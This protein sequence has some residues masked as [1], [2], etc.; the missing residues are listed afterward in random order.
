VSSTWEE[1]D[2]QLKGQQAGFSDERGCLSWSYSLMNDPAWGSDCPTRSL[3]QLR[4]RVMEVNRR[5]LKQR[6]KGIE[7]PTME[8]QAQPR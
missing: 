4:T 2:Q 7:L 8:V 5:R 6:L 3:Q 1:I